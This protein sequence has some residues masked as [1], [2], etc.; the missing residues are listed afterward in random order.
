MTRARP[1]RS[2]AIRGGGPLTNGP[3]QH[4]LRNR[5]YLGELNHRG[6]SFAA[7]HAAILDPELFAAVQARL[8]ANRRAHRAKKQ[9]TDALL[10]GLLFDDRGN[11]MS[12]CYAIKKGMRYRYYTSTA[13]MQGRK[14]GGR[15]G[16]PGGGPGHRS[17]ADRCTRDREARSAPAGRA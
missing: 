9:H 4:L 11:R 5:V 12:P 15:I 6:Q 14:D 17:R 13:L 10:T 7:E 1:L 8:D 16:G 2:G 3:L